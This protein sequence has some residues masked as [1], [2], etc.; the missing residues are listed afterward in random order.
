MYN[1]DIY[2]LFKIDEHRELVKQ[3]GSLNGT[4]VPTNLVTGTGTYPSELFSL[5]SPY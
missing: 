5:P 3:A 1:A 4:R 2:V